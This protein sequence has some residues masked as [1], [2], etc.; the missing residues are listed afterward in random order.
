MAF[1]DRVRSNFAPT[2]LR[3][4]RNLWMKLDLNA[5]G[6]TMAAFE[7]EVTE[8]G[9]KVIATH[10]GPGWM[11]HALYGRGPGG[12][13]PLSKMIAWI[14]ARRLVMNPYAL[15]K[16]IAEEGTKRRFNDRGFIDQLGI[17]AQAEADK[18]LDSEFVI[19]EFLL[20][21]EKDILAALRKQASGTRQI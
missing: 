3:E 16:R 15:Q 2:F 1:V 14:A 20:D 6:Q 10:Y 5:T 11:Y 13:P 21:F 7:V 8:K 17:K 18:F 9:D 4:S 12:K 19:T